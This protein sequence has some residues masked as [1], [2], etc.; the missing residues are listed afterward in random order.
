MTKIIID[1]RGSVPEEQFLSRKKLA[2][3]AAARKKRGITKIKRHAPNGW[4]SVEELIAFARKFCTEKKLT[5]KLAKHC[6]I[7]KWCVRRWLIGERLPLQYRLNQIAAFIVA[8]KRTMK[9]STA[10]VI[11]RPII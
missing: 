9:A 3:L 7:S 8:K 6:Q 2:Q 11:G 10:D 5:G 1:N 4:K